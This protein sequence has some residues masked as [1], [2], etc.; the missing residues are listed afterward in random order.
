MG[1]SYKRQRTTQE[2]GDLVGIEF[3]LFNYY[4]NTLR[5]PLIGHW[6]SNSLPRPLSG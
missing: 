6:L 3:N 4:L 5:V 1:Y 2:L